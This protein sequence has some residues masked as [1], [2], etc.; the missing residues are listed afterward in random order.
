M[1]IPWED[2]DEIEVQAILYQYFLSLDYKVDWIHFIEP[3]REKNLGCDLVCTKNKETI[4]IAVKKKPRA[5]DGY[6]VKRLAQKKYSRRF[7]VYLKTP[8]VSFIEQTKNYSS[9]VEIMDIRE[10]EKEMRKNEIGLII[11]CCINYS[12]SGFIQFVE[13]FLK[14]IS[15]IVKEKTS[16][17]SKEAK[18]LPELWR[19]KDQAVAMSRSIELLLTIFEKTWFYA[20]TDPQ[21]LYLIFN[22]VLGDLENKMYNFYS[23][24][25]KLL[26]KN[27]G[28]IIKAHDKYGTRS[29]WLGLWNLGDYL[30]KTKVYAPGILR[31]NLK[32]L[33]K[34]DKTE[35]EKLEKELSLL[36]EE[37]GRVYAP[38]PI[39]ADFVTEKLLRAFFIFTDSLEGI[40]DDI[41]EV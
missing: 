1:Q 32:K 23:V 34:I 24:W 18:P 26:E 13:K 15:S 22:E 35:Y 4:G 8:S 41:F 33:T 38:T 6:Q 20:E 2:F 17:I 27:K 30:I 31:H 40:I 37:R 12:N 19:L 9:R 25:Q 28:L 21:V 11:L 3:T 29:N 39:L 5:K 10:I 16:N 7:F 36:F 14:E